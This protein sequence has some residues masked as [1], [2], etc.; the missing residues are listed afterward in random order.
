MSSLT[1]IA[2]FLE[3]L[4]GNELWSRFT[5][6]LVKCGVVAELLQT[7]EWFIFSAAAAV[8]AYAVF[9]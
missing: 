8:P 2:Q 5:L 1:I 9:L 7:K 4:L 6:E 3:N